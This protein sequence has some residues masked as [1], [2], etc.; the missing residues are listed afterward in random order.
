MN[1]SY[2]PVSWKIEDIIEKASKEATILIPDL[3]RPYVWTPS[4]VILLMDSIL[5]VGLLVHCLY[6][7]SGMECIEIMKEFPTENFGK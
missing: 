1:I 3:Q 6:G 2:D 7:K 5:E 4:Q